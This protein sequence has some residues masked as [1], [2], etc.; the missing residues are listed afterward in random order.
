MAFVGFSSWAFPDD[1]PERSI[2][3]AH[4]EGFDGVEFAFL[5]EG[6]WEGRLI[7]T[8]RHAERLAAS[9]GG[10]VRSVHAPIDQMALASPD[11]QERGRS[12]DLLL[13]TID[14]AAALGAGVVVAHLRHGHA[15]GQPSWLDHAGEP[16]RRCGDRAAERGLIVGVENYGVGDDHADADYAALAALIDRVGHPAVRMT[17]DVGHANVHLGPSDGVG[18]AARLFGDRVAHYHVHDNFGG[19]DDHLPVGQGS[20]DLSSLATRDWSSSPAMLML[21]VFPFAIPDAAPGLRDSHRILREWVGASGSDASSLDA[22]GSDAS[23][24]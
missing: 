16:L 1:P 13:E 12:Q 11:S 5:T 18:Q 23:G 22:S 14:A 3:F 7:P 4:Q 2:D 15:Q 21:E 19:A 6:L 17:L 8:E 20:A 10:L 24:S 9:C